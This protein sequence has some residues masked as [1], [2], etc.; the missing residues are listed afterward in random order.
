MSYIDECQKAER[1]GRVTERNLAINIRVTGTIIRVFR[2]TQ[3]VFYVTILLGVHIVLPIAKYYDGVT[4]RPSS[5]RY[6]GSEKSDLALNPVQIVGGAAVGRA[7]SIDDIA[8][9]VISI[10][11]ISGD[12]T[13]RCR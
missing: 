6:I 13:R 7:Q 2:T 1:T 12:K 3:I 10:V 8:H 9:T 4:D 5:W 11:F